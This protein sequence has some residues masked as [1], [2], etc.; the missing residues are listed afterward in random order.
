M[1][2]N[3]ISFYFQMLYSNFHHVRI[4]TINYRPDQL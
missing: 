2:I 3:I 1:V 4:S